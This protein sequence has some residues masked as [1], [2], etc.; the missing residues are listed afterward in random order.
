MIIYDKDNMRM[1]DI[2][3]KEIMLL[4]HNPYHVRHVRGDGIQT[5]SIPHGS[6]N[7]DLTS[8]IY[9]IKIILMSCAYWYGFFH[10]RGLKLSILKTVTECS[11][12][13]FKN[14]DNDRDSNHHF[15]SPYWSSEKLK[16]IV[17]SYNNNVSEEE[18]TPV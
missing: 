3:N 11:H 13:E 12:T 15:Q 10:N 2:F 14:H 9:S 17:K 1:N 5:N 6:Y 8:E 16:L 18:A 4:L 7:H